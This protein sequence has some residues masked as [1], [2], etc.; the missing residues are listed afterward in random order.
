MMHPGPP[1]Y[2]GGPAEGAG[3]C[4]LPPRRIALRTLLVMLNPLA[5]KG[6]ALRALDVILPIFEGAGIRAE[7]FRTQAAGDVRRMA[8]QRDLRSFDAVCV[9]GG[10]G[11]IAEALGGLMARAD[12]FKLPIAIVPCGTGNSFAAD[13]GRNRATPEQSARSIV[14]G[15]VRQADSAWMELGPVSGVHFMNMVDWPAD[16]VKRAESMRWMG[17]ARYNVAAT[18]E[19]MGGR[20]GRHVRMIIDEVRRG[21]CLRV[22]LGLQSGEECGGL[23]TGGRKSSMCGGGAH[24]AP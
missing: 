21:G 14:Q 16:Y 23:Q 10:D 9:L 24:E 15:N 1:A 11:T 13:F 22:S 7:V 5:G 6:K 18:M 3:S 2:A 8:Q 4:V 17:P 12:G 20:L 19:I